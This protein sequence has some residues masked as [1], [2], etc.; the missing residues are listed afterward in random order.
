MIDF[1]NEEFNNEDILTLTDGM[2]TIEDSLSNELD[3]SSDGERLSHLQR[4]SM[5]LRRM[6]AKSISKSRCVGE[7]KLKGTN[8]LP[9]LGFHD[10][11][12]I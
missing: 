5:I 10:C 9:C 12:M 7:D 3:E 11:M 1:Q 2:T 8:S 4:R 6:E